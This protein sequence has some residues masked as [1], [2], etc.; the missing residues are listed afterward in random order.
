M[1]YRKCFFIE[2]STGKKGIGT[3]ASVAMGENK[4]KK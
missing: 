1:I 2:I 3:G 4:F